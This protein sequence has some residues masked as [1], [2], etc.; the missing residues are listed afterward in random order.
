MRFLLYFLN[1]TDDHK[2]DGT[3]DEDVALDYFDPFLV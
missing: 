1:Y 3:N 2:G